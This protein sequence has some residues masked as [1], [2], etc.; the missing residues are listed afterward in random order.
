[1]ETCPFCNYREWRTVEVQDSW[2]N[3]KNFR[4]VC[5][6]CD[7]MGPIAKSADM[8]EKK[9]GGL[10]SKIDSAENEKY[11]KQILKEGMDFKRGKDLKRALSL[12]L[13]TK[14]INATKEAYSVDRFGDKLWEEIIVYLLNEGYSEDEIEW[15]LLSKHMRWAGDFMEGYDKPINLEG[16]IEYLETDKNGLKED[17]EGLP[18]R[19]NEEAMGGVSTPGATLANTPGMGNAQPAASTSTGS[20]DGASKGS[21]DNWDSSTGKMY[22]QESNINP[23]DKLGV[24]MAQ[25]M[26]IPLAFKK[27][28]GDKDVEQIEIAEDIDL[29]TKLVTFEDWAKQFLGENKIFESIKIEGIIYDNISS[30]GKNIYA[31]DKGILGDN[32][33]FISWDIIQKLFLKYANK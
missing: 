11:F 19:T 16:F 8:A 4:V 14:I 26:G 21:G 2:T 5:E 24:A 1:M 23:H 12:G 10:L 25:K 31:G 9:W 22:V 17:L 27:G 7:A 30:F 28:K 13:V 33:V 29:S 18:G 20:L 15:A 6:V 32:G 3:E